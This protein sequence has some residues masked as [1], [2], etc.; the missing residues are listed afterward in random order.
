[1]LKPCP[2]CGSRS[3]KL[4]QNASKVEDDGGVKYDFQ[5]YYIRCTKCKSRGPLFYREQ[6]AVSAWNGRAKI[7]V[8]NILTEEE[9]QTMRKASD[10]M[11]KFTT[12]K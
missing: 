4:S 6:T 1:M 10:I 2:F 3:V 5:D 8:E 12:R 11:D 7:N 9:L